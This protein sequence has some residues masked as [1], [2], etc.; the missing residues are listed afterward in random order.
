MS[1]YII[2]NIDFTV[3]PRLDFDHLEDADKPV[4]TFPN[5]YLGKIIGEKGEKLQLKRTRRGIGEEHVPN[6][7]LRNEDGIALIRIHNKEDIT[8]F[9]L[10]ENTQNDVGDCVGV[11]QSSYPFAY[12]VID[13]RDD[14]CQL[15]I[16]K[17]SSW[18]SKTSTI[19][20]CLEKYFNDELHESMGITT[21]LQEKTE[22]KDF[23]E[24][25]DQRTIDHG[26]LIE[27]FTFEFVNVN[28]KPTTRIPES[29]TEQMDMYSKILEFYSA[30]SGITTVNMDSAIDNEKLKQLSTV[31]VYSMDNAFD[32]KVKFKDYGDYS[33]RD[34]VVAKY[35]M[36]DAVI[37]N[38]KDYLNPDA[39]NS[40]FDLESW[41]DEVYMKVKEGKNG[42]EIPTK[43]M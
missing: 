4:S 10:P 12:V 8:I 18:D 17:D 30:A 1:D 15:A 34:G 5:Y 28:R 29:L 25:I 26:D 7:V 40:D 9:E 2:H 24:F 35:P 38:F 43:P 6:C 3:N 31:M 21:S 42:K 19:K 16:E 41:L 22:R 20:N 14:R 36:N 27:S 33:C 13:Y 32:L 11:Q 23:E 39:L 37:S